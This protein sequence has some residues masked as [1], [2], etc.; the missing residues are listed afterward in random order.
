MPER[1]FTTLETALMLAVY[2]IV[3]FL[4]GYGL[5]VML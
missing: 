4:M 3:V 2:T 5:G 1:E